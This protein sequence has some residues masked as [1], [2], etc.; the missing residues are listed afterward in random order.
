M[1]VHRRPRAFEYPAQFHRNIDT[2]VTVVLNLRSKKVFLPLLA[3]E[4]LLINLNRNND[5]IRVALV[6]CLS[7]M[8]D[9]HVI[10]A[11]ETRRTRLE[12]HRIAL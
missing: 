8:N 5:Y 2:L 6:L 10:K 7:L 12:T 9:W 4:A 3:L 1:R 11:I